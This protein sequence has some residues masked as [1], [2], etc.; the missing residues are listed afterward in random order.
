MGCNH[1]SHVT[2]PSNVTFVLGGHVSGLNAGEQVTLEDNGD[3]SLTVTA[4]GAFAFESP[5]AQGGSYLITVATQPVG[6]T[7]TVANYTGANVTANVS[8]INVSCSVDSFTIGGTVTGLNSGAQLTLQDSGADALAVAANGAFTF[9]TPVA[10][11]G[12]Y[13]VTVASEPAGQICTVSNGAGSAV[14]ANVTNVSVL[15]SADTFTVGGAVTGLASGVQVTLYDNGSDPLTVSSNGPYTFTLPV[16]YNGSYNVT[17]GTQPTGQTCTVTNG[18]GLATAT[19]ITNVNVTCSTS[20]FTIS[21][22]ISNLG[23]GTQVTLENNGSDPLNITTNGAFTF[24]TPVSYGGSYSVTVGTQPTGQ[25]CTVSSASGMPVTADVTDVSVLCAMDTFTVSGTVSGLTASGLVLK[26]NSGDPISVGAGNTTFVFDIPVAYGSSYD[27][28]VFQQPTGLTCSVNNAS[29]SN[30]TANVSNVSIACAVS[31]YTIGGAIAGLTASGLVLQDNSSDNLTV[32]VSDT[33]FQFA[34]PVAYG[35]SYNVTV[36][37]QPSTQTC[38]VSSGTGANVTAIVTNVDV[39]CVT[40]TPTLTSLTPNSGPPT[41]GTSVTLTGTYFVAG[42]TSV[43]MGGTVIPASSVTVNSAT[44]LTFNTPVHGSGNA[45]VSVTTPVGTSATVP[46]GFT[47]VGYTVGGTVSGLSG[48]VI[49]L[50]NGSDATTVTSNG[51]FTFPTPIGEGSSYNVTVGTQPAGQT[52]TVTNGSGAMGGSNVT[53]VNVSCATNTTSLSSSLSALALETSGNARTITITNT[54]SSP[55]ENL[56]I[57]YPTWPSGT[58]ASSTCGSVLSAMNTC[59]LTITPGANATSSCNSPYSAPTPGVITVSASNV[60]SSVTTNVV[61]LT[62]GCIYQEGYV[63][64]IDDTTATSGSIG[65]TTAALADNSSAI[66]WYN[67]SFVTTNAQSLTDGATNTA[68]IISDQ[69]AGSYAAETTANYMIDSSGNSPCSTGTCYSNWYLPAICQMTDSAAGAGC[70]SGTPN[71]ESNLPGLISGCSGS[72]CLTG[73][74]WSSAEY[75]SDPQ[76]FAWDAYFSSGGS[77]A[78]S[79]I[80]FEQFAVRAVRALTP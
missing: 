18:N 20:T 47:Y 50:N 12:A 22:S 61:V 37:Q 19:N 65:G 68:T 15:C 56:S 27:V 80:K 55:A 26:D 77:S 13:N 14:I 60:A 35:A 45:A 49:L 33:T 3:N 21:G 40:N 23:A 73:E 34:T 6:E 79:D 43:N 64:A 10:Y 41:G 44:S 72:A 8:S 11:N 5:V 39:D 36:F 67:G 46:G 7:C 54:G 52:C 78:F 57:N 25:I 71:M 58:G 51:S 75:S 63:F 66:E 32:S 24:A 4:N 16:A 29:G 69:G 1:S 74:Y 38:T 59:T 9:A 30:V 28:T 76:H 31:T 42:N 2:A 48:T 70:S 53:N 62:Y 17:V